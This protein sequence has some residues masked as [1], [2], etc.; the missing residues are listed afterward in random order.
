MVFLSHYSCKEFYLRTCHPK[1]C[2]PSPPSCIGNDP[3]G[4]VGSTHICAYPSAFRTPGVI[5]GMHSSSPDCRLSYIICL[6]WHLSV[7]FWP[8][9]FS[10]LTPEARIR[11]GVHPLKFQADR[12]V[13][14]VEPMLCARFPVSIRSS[15]DPAR[16]QA[17]P[18]LSSSWPCP[19]GRQ[20]ASRHLVGGDVP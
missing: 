4:S 5:I 13:F 16:D 17:A 8:G 15:Q 19:P 1:T 14:P 11:V 9:T 20:T 18:G 3:P 2:S 6:E 12:R 10:H 7:A